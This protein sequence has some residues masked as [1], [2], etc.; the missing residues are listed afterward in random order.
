MRTSILVRWLFVWCEPDEHPFWFSKHP[1]CQVAVIL[2]ILFFK[3]SWCKRAVPQA[4]AT[5]FLPS[6]LF[7]SFF[8]GPR[9]PVYTVQISDGIKST[10]ARLFRPRP[11]T[12]SYREIGS[13]HRIIDDRMENSINGRRIQNNLR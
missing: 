8:N 10:I 12:T 13:K 5:T 11:E 3:S 4:A 1:F 7:L 9:E 6:L 2:L